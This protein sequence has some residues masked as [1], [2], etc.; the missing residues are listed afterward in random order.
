M[1]DQIKFVLNRIRERLWIKPLLVCLLS[2]VA[3]LLAHTLDDAVSDRMIPDITQESIEDLLKLTAASMLVIATLAVASMVSAY[4]SAGSTATPR[5]LPLVIADDVS[6]N[7]LSTFIGVFIFCIVALIALLNGY[8]GK[9]GRFALFA[10]MVV[11]LAMVI[12]TFVRWVDRIAR[13]GRLGSVIDKVEQ[14]TAIALQRRRRTPTLR[15]M[16]AEVGADGGIPVYAQDI[17]YVQRVDVQRLQ[18]CAEKS[19]IVITVAALP[20]TFA[21]PSEPI[22][23]V[24]VDPGNVR[25][26][27][28][29]TIEKAF[30]IGDDRLFDED[31]RFGIVALSEIASRALSPAVNDPGT[32]IDITGTFVRLFAAWA[33]PLD[34]DV[35]L[36]EIT[37][38]RVRVPELD[39][40][41]M[42]D[43]AFTGIARDGAGILEVQIRLQK[44]LQSL[45]TVGDAGMRA[46][47]V[48]H[49]R[50]ALARAEKAMTLAEDMAAVRAASGVVA[51]P[52]HA[53]PGG[54]RVGRTG[55]STHPS[56]ANP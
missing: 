25:E 12:V 52:P 22:A 46:A 7:A 33:A 11:A 35:E 13:L 32:A 49:S 47:A 40:R 26:L 20:G 56:R 1:G 34:D 3:A 30:I 10:L 15:A 51:A 17:G 8:Y 39:V 5:S 37:C 23:Y 16:R 36:A 21:A 42:L 2:V 31:P 4:A 48:A 44:A 50:L 24:K 14:A 9:V 18:A 55:G 43:D 54:D 6:Q 27:D 45:A 53:P 19:A 28:H 29:A 38:D 41:D